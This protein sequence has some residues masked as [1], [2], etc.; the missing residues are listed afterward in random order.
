MAI[1][2]TLSENVNVERLAELQRR[3]DSAAE[4]ACTY[5]EYADEAADSAESE[6]SA[7]YADEAAYMSERVASLAGALI[8]LIIN[9]ERAALQ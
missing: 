8:E 2:I 7:E 6:Y 3:L 1:T 9:A 5:A 4:K